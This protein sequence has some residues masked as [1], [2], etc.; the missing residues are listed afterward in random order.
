MDKLIYRS[1]FPVGSS[2]FL[3]Y[4]NVGEM[5]TNGAEMSIL[6]SPTRRFY[7]ELSGTYQDTTDRRPG[8]E[9]IE[10][11]YSP[12]F[13]GYLKASYFINKDIS[14]A[15]TGN[16]VDKMESYFDDTLIPPGRLGDR[17][18]GYF[19]LG[20]NLRVRNF[21]TTGM[22]L[23]LKVSN[24]LDEEIRYPATASN[25]LY[26]TKGTIGRGRSFLLTLGWKF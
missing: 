7:F 23:N 17:V 1:I 25:N 16:Y 15:V 26:A 6:F 14:L 19:L 3:Y 2:I 8:F 4:S 9:N 18:G 21:L 22:F 5:T 11:G 24:L 13:L 10:V 12:K 20:A